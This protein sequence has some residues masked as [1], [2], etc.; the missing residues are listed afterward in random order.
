MQDQIIAPAGSPAPL[1][2]AEELADHLR[3]STAH[4][5]KLVQRGRIP[6]ISL[7]RARRFELDRVLAALREEPS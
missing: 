1:L 5:W 2:T 6:T 3:V 4:V 7:G